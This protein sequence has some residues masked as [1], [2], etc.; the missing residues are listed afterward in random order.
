MTSLLN[1]TGASV[2]PRTVHGCEF[3]EL[4]PKTGQSPLTR[5]KFLGY[6]KNE[7]DGDPTPDYIGLDSK[8]C[9]YVT[10]R[11]KQSHNARRFSQNARNNA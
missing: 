3:R 8:N 2:R 6:L 1:G 4:H 7:L 11:G 10:R 5:G 9:E